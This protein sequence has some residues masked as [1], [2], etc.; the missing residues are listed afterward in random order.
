M[1]LLVLFPIM[2]HHCIVMNHLKLHLHCKRDRQMHFTG[3]RNKWIKCTAFECRRRRNFSVWWEGLK[4]REANFCRIRLLT[5]IN[6]KYWQD[7]LVTQGHKCLV[8]IWGVRNKLFTLN[9][10]S[11]PQAFIHSLSLVTTDLTCWGNFAK[12][13]DISLNA[14]KSVTATLLRI[15]TDNGRWSVSNKTQPDSYTWKATWLQRTRNEAEHIATRLGQHK[16]CL[17]AEA[18]CCVDDDLMAVTYSVPFLRHHAG[19]RDAPIT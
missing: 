6:F 5:R 15:F 13:L 12:N 3:V 19:P 4:R 7:I 9:S 16:L 8:R 10:P 18:G 11:F 17:R 1:H 14:L 2:N